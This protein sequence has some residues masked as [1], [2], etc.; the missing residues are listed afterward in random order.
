MKASGFGR[1][2][3][4]SRFSALSLLA[5]QPRQLR[6]D[7]LL[8][9]RPLGQGE[10]QRLLIL[11]S[12]L[13]SVKSRVFKR[14]GGEVDVGMAVKAN[15]SCYTSSDNFASNL[16]LA[17]DARGFDELKQ[18]GNAPQPPATLLKPSIRERKFPGWKLP[19]PRAPHQ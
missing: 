2:E 11:R 6:P 16:I 14:A 1:Q 3:S 8:A 10:C 12:Y 4:A 9:G 7:L 17:V 19:P 13:T 18:D 15:G 5:A